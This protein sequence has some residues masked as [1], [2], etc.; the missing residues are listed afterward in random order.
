MDEIQAVSEVDMK[1]KLHAAV[2]LQVGMIKPADRRVLPRSSPIASSWIHSNKCK[3]SSSAL[4]IKYVHKS[5]MLC[6]RATKHPAFVY[7]RDTSAECKEGH[8]L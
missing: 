2:C 3:M 6:A 5:G 4:C 8:L 1:L 7:V